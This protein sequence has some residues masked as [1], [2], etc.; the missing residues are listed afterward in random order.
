MIGGRPDS[1]QLAGII[2]PIVRTIDPDLVIVFGSAARATMTPESDVDLVVVKDV[3]NLRELGRR[4][5]E[6][7]PRPHPPVDIVPATRAL[8]SNHRESLSWVYGPAMA[9]GIVAYERGRNHARG[10]ERAW[11]RI[12]VDESREQRMVRVFRYQRDETLD[13]LDKARKDLTV[14]RSKDAEIDPEARCYSAQAATEKSLK[15]LLVAHGQ[16]VRA[17]HDLEGFADELR[18]QGE[19]LPAVATAQELKRLAEYAGAAQY[20]GWAGETTEADAARFCEIAVQVYERAR[21]RAPQILRAHEP[22]APVRGR[23]S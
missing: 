3:A 19:V 4:T 11:D 20:P 22:S 10:S 15:A 9:D 18:A 16:P 6:C 14:V 12:A 7:L 17:E 23:E 2:S 5:R 21:E 13:W 1:D 8:L